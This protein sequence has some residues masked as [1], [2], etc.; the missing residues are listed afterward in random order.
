MLNKPWH[1]HALFFSGLIWILSAWP[2]AHLR[3]QALS[4]LRIGCPDL[5][6]NCKKSW[7]VDFIAFLNFIIECMF[8]FKC[9]SWLTFVA[10]AFLRSVAVTF[11]PHTRCN[12][13]LMPEDVNGEGVQLSVEGKVTNTFLN[14]S[15]RLGA[16]G[17]ILVT[18]LSISFHKG[19]SNTREAG[20]ICP[21]LWRVTC[22]KMTFKFNV[23]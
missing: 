9:A 1:H 21:V 4:R 17:L 5:F 3:G 15:C 6:K 10:V 22:N 23:R 18:N 13:L 19:G 16:R 11:S 7:N 20:T 8:Q 12:A 2:M 14:P